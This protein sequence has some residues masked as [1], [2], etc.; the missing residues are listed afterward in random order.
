M[1]ILVQLDAALASALA[2]GI[3]ERLNRHI[4]LGRLARAGLR[5]LG[6]RMLTPNLDRNSVVTAAYVPEGVDAELLVENVREQTGV[7]LAAGNGELAKSVVRVGHCGYIDSFDVVVAVAALEIG[8]RRLGSPVVPG[9]GVI[10]VLQAL[11]DQHGPALS[12]VASS[13]AALDAH[14]SP[15]RSL[16]ADR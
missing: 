1:G 15:V 5:G 13:G 10:P 16:S 3:D 7:Q 4:M 6:L 9:A 11:S 2:E 12:R 8:L 14:E